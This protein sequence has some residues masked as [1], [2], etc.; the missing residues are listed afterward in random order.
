MNQTVVI[1]DPTTPERAARYVDL[2]PP[3]L[4]LAH[5]TARGDAHL[6]EVIAEADYAIAGQVAVSGDVLR[7]ARKLKLLHKFGVGVD[8]LD[9]ATAKALG[10]VVARTTGSNAVPVAELT[11]G[12]MFSAL[13]LIPY[14]HAELQ[15]G[16]WRTSRLPAETFTLSRKTVGIVGFGAIGQ[17][18]ARLLRGFD[19]RILYAKRSA[20]P[21]HEEAAL[22][23]R[24]ASLGELLA[25]SDV[26]T[27]NCPLTPE[28]AGMIDAAALRLMKRSAVLINVAR[29][30]VVV[31]SDLVA[32]LRA[33]IILGAAM[34][35][36]ETEP[37]P[38]DSPLL[39]LDNLV[40]T[41][42]LGAIASDNFNPTVRRMFAN[43]ACMMRG[44]PI[45]S[46]DRVV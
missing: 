5:A 34:D 45:P 46:S 15:R 32:A 39:T 21:A 30:G 44:E 20:L 41:P 22:G 38:P 9:L 18:I 16:E 10:I 29:G 2:L 13:R 33:R 36:F 37:L 4:A 14:A 43:I 24:R 19:C 23:A 7:A 28:T 17:T 8:N 25:A 6:Q 3:G 35:V 42:H 27:L 12:L 26:V 11:L 31:E 40:V 1:L